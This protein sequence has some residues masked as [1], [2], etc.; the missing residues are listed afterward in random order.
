M[1]RSRILVIDD[2][3]PDLI[4]DLKEAGYSVDY[5][6]DIGSGSLHKI[7]NYDLVILDF[8]KVGKSMGDEQGLSL[9][10][11][12]KRTNPSVIVLAY[13]S[14]SLPSE[15]A[16]FYRLADNVL[17]KDAGIAE[18][19]EFIDEALRK[20]HNIENLWRGLVA[21]AGITE[22]GSEDLKLQ[23]MYVNSINNPQKRESFKSRA[24]TLARTD[25]ARK[26]ALGVIEKLLEIGGL[27]IITS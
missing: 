6:M 14:W 12:I 11:H 26:L 3:R 13:T 27:A 20:A 9:L 24:I 5:E 21:A 22:G 15:H 23:H 7:R 18:S 16:D 10:R 1:Q 2:E 4:D 25:E 17:S 19:T 8:G